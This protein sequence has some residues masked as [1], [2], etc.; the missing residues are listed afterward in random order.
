MNRTFFII[1][2]F[3]SLILLSCSFFGDIIRDIRTEF[4][5]RDI[6][7]EY[8]SESKNYAGVVTFGQSDGPDFDEMDTFTETEVLLIPISAKVTLHKAIDTEKIRTTIYKVHDGSIY[9]QDRYTNNVSKDWPEFVINL[10]IYSPGF[11]KVDFEY[12]DGEMIASGTVEVF[13]DEE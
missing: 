12:E 8:E 3:L 13:E 11:Y 9:I 7:Q 6:R 2:L 1:L 4:I 5:E 10:P